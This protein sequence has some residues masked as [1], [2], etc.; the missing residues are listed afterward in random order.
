MD[1]PPQ[2]P[3]PVGKTNGEHEGRKTGA[4][5]GFEKT[6]VVAVG[7]SSSRPSSWA[8]ALAAEFHAGLRS[9]GARPKRLDEDYLHAWGTAFDRLAALGRWSAE[10]LR[11]T[12]L[13]ASCDGMN[14]ERRWEGWAHKM[15]SPDYLL[16]PRHGDIQFVT[17][18]VTR[19]KARDIAAREAHAERRLR[20]DLGL[21]GDGE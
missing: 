19:L 11:E 18:F 5:P 17:I 21:D 4:I 1:R 16:R 2:Q 9:A 10:E 6:R 12:L 15:L 13:W 3:P 14:V 20:R 7:G 8:R